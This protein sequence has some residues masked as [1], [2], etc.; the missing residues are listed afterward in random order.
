MNAKIKLGHVRYYP[1]LC[2]VLPESI[3]Y[4]PKVLDI[5][6]ST[7]ERKVAAFTLRIGCNKWRCLKHITQE[8]ILAVFLQDQDLLHLVKC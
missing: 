6:R 8:A 5:T 3:L 2:W 1:Q 4:Y 7:V